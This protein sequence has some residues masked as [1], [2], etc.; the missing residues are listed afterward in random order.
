MRISDWSSDVCS[1][2]LQPLGVDV[3]HHIR[4]WLII[5]RVARMDIAGVHQYDRT[6]LYLEIRLLMKVGAAPGR[7]RPDGKVVMGMTRIADLAPVGV[8]SEERRVGIERVST[9]SSRCSPFH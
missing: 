2:D 6:A 5:D 4:P 8:R 1:S 3:Q 7:D 9:C